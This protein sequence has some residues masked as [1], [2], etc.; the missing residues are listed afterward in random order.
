MA[1]IHRHRF[2]P[3]R[4]LLLAVALVMPLTF[5]TSCSNDE[6]DMLVGYYMTIDSKVRL[7]LY[8][9]DESQGT[10]SSPIVDVLSY[11]LVQMRTA[12][13]NAYPQ[14]N[15]HGNDAKVIAACDGIYKKYKSMYGAEERNTVCI[16]KLY[17]ASMDGEVVKRSKA[18]K[19]YRFGARPVNED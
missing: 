2:A 12:L 13:R 16:V 7:S 8:E 11:T 14:N 17:R 4:G 10:S 3:L 5:M 1:K 18:L 15:T 19:T 6:P 9:E